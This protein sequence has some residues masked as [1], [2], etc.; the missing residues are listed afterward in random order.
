[1]LHDP[2]DYPDYDA[3]SKLIGVDK[4]SFLT[5]QPIETYSTRDIREAHSRECIYYDEANKTIGDNSKRN[6][7]PARYSFINCLTDCRAAVIKQKC[8]CIPYYYLQNS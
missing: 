1:M 6:F 2:Y 4:Y 3:P 7:I 8:G 5:V